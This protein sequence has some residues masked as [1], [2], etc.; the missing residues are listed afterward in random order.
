[1]DE[2]N[3]R[4]R[5]ATVRIAAA[6]ALG[7]AFALGVYLL[8][9]SANPNGLV[10][11]TFL[12]LLPAVIT[13]FI[14]YVGDPLAERPRSFYLAAVPFWL[15]A[16]VVVAS[17]AILHEGVICILMLAPFWF[18]LSILG[19]W[20]AWR[21]RQRA[22]PVENVFRASSLLLLPLVAMQVE[23]LVPLPRD[24]ASVT[25]SVIID[26]EPATV[27]RHARASDGLQPGEGR[28]NVSQDVIGLPRPIGAR[29]DREGLGATRRVEWQ[30]GIRFREVVTDWQPGR[31]LWW[32]FRFPAQDMDAWAMQDRHLLPDSPHYRI[33]DGGY[34]L[35]PLPG[36]RTRLTLTT[37]YWAQTPVNWYAR[38]WGELLIGDVSANVLAVVR[39][40]AEAQR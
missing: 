7:L 1:M 13:A 8:I 4:R 18:V 20:I 16:A 6:F 12:L 3:E 25:R 32:N 31:R 9:Q 33:V 15:L 39:Q 37:R 29:L 19:G 34:D 14:A 24:A 27:W 21:S 22:E 11:F 5:T 23:P 38:A 36:G 30:Q 35:T 10:S 40:R 28:W 17:L 2:T 26:A